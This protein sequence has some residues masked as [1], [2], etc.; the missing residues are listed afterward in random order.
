MQTIWSQADSTEYPVKRIRSTFVQRENRIG[1]RSM[2]LRRRMSKSF[3]V[4]RRVFGGGNGNFARECFIIPAGI[5]LSSPRHPV[6][7]NREYGHD[8]DIGSCGYFWWRGGCYYRYPGG[9]WSP[10]LTPDYCGY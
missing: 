2:P 4:E 7:E 10:L 8:A 5:C 6:E 1:L 9:A 3:S